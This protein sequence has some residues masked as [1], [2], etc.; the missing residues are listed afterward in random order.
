MR[1]GMTTMKYTG[2]HDFTGAR[3]ITEYPPMPQSY[4][5][6]GDPDWTLGI[7]RML[8]SGKTAAYIPPSTTPYDISAT[9][10]QPLGVDD[11]TLAQGATV[12]AVS[13]KKSIGQLESKSY[14]GHHNRYNS[15]VF[16]SS[17]SAHRW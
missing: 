4:R 8:D 6:P 3:F 14:R 2:T 10:T 17:R 12:R 13:A 1:D 15:L 5:E 11:L 16:G 9:L 7:Q